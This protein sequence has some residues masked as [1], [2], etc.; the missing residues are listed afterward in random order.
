MLVFGQLRPPYFPYHNARK[1]AYP[2]PEYYRQLD[3]VPAEIVDDIIL[4]LFLSG[5]EDEKFWN[6]EGTVH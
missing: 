2:V 5:D 6:D 1:I 3:L 4:H